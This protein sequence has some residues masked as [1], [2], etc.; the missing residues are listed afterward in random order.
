MTTGSR[1][2]CVRIKRGTAITPTQP[3]RG[4]IFDS[5]FRASSPG[6]LKARTSARVAQLGD[7]RTRHLVNMLRNRGAKTLSGHLTFRHHNS[8]RSG[9][10]VTETDGSPSPSPVAVLWPE[11]IRVL[12]CSEV[13]S[14]S[15]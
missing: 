12:Y 4:V 2:A 3:N 5:S 1:I 11:L 15:V 8:E 7:G 6:R 13:F 14:P 9:T 10:L